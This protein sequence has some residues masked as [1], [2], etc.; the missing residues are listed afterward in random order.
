M[1]DLSESAIVKFTARTGRHCGSCSLCCRLLDVPEVGKQPAQQCSHCRPGKGCSIYSE[2]PPICRNYACLWL[3]DPSFGDAWFPAEC[4]IVADLHRQQDSG[5]T[6]LR[7]HVD[8]RRPNRWRE[9]PYYSTI[10]HLSLCGLRNSL[11]GPGEPYLTVISIASKHGLLVLPHKEVEYGPG[12]AL[13]VGPDHF[14]YVHCNST[15]DARR[16]LLLLPA[17]QEE[18]AAIHRQYPDMPLA[19]RFEHIAQKLMNDPRFAE[20]ETS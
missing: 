20:T 2:R 18:A 19:Q 8:P 7:F 14:E 17:M 9:E 13:P 11:G 10:K 1:I 15:D 6:V 3:I 12:I 4:G 16:L 5:N